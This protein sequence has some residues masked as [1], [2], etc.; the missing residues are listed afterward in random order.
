MAN[1]V[2]ALIVPS[3]GMGDIPAA[4]VGKTETCC[5]P[6]WWVL[7]IKRHLHMKINLS[8]LMKTIIFLIVFHFLKMRPVKKTTKLCTFQIAQCTVISLWP[9]WMMCLT[10]LRKRFRRKHNNGIVINEKH[11][12]L[13]WPQKAI[14]IATQALNINYE[15]PHKLPWNSMNKV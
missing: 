9:I 11:S 4:S 5:Q 14:K 15:S 8:L 10:Y 2:M 12:F 13:Y 1:G 3:L 7:I 6:F